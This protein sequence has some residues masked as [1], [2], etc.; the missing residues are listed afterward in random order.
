[1][2]LRQNALVGTKQGVKRAMTT[3]FWIGE[4][5]ETAWN[6]DLGD[7][8]IGVSDADE[9]ACDSSVWDKDWIEHFGGADVDDPELAY[10]SALPFK[11]KENPFYCALP[12]CDFDSEDA[13]KSTVVH[14]PWYSR[15]LEQADVVGCEPLLKNRWVHI[16]RHVSS[17]TLHCYAQWE[18]AGPY[19]ED[20]WKYVFG[21]AKRPLN[22]YNNHAG[23]DLSPACWRQLE[24]DD[25][26]YTEWEFVEASQVPEGPWKQ[27]VTTSGVNR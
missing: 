4:G 25:N 2:K 7:L 16:Q 9:L 20:D 5:V 27:V 22:R 23:L 10:P 3:M 1:M 26:G 21:R 11:P 15:W 6:K 14:I 8:P 18:D 12:Y 19:G 24:M 13:L 17:I